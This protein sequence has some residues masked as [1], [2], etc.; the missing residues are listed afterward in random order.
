M[1]LF[2]FDGSDV[3]VVL[4]DDEP[5]F[6]ASDVCKVLGIQ[7]VGN[8]LARLDELSIRQADVENARGQMR[9][10][11]IVNE[12]GLYELVLRSDKPQ[13]RKFTRWVT[14]EVL[15]QIRK[16]GKYDRFD[17]NNQTEAL[18]KIEAGWLALQGEV[19]RLKP[20]AEVRDGIYDYHGGYTRNEVWK[21]ARSAD[22]FE[23]SLPEF[24]Q[25]LHGLGVTEARGK[26]FVMTEKFYEWA[27]DSQYFSTEHK[28]HR[29][30]KNPHFNEV[31][32]D[33]I[34]SLIK[35]VE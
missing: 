35:G 14:R 19:D 25:K 27:D 3:R 28:E 2:D 20:K 4:V 12:P 34:L 22:L 29:P 33:G 11:K 31:G 24:N 10:T 1:Q 30:N 9:K 5:W 32:K 7:N 21:M 18:L 16:T 17:P 13:A 6:V 8:A 26:S 23:G 15:P